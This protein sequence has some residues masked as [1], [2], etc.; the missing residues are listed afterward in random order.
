MCVS[1]AV[2]NLETPAQLTACYAGLS[3]HL[4]PPTDKMWPLTVLVAC[5]EICM[6]VWTV[7]THRVH[8]AAS[9]H[10][11]CFSSHS[12]SENVFTYFTLAVAIFTYGN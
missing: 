10:A 7:D 2:Q 8:M 3:A 12:I 9:V 11:F 6:C 4:L 1:V 5:V